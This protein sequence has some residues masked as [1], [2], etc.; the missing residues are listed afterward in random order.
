MDFG[1]VGAFVEDLC[2][3]FRGGG[4]VDHGFGP[5][6]RRIFVASINSF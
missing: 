4:G 3:S 5:L 1:F 2:V 6:E